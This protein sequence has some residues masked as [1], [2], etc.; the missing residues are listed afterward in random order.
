MAKSSN[1]GLVGSGIALDRC[2]ATTHF[3]QSL[4]KTSNLLSYIDSPDRWG[5]GG[6]GGVV[7]NTLN[8]NKYNIKY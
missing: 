4:T 5:G 7:P 1:N 2:K 3:S 6:G 8:G